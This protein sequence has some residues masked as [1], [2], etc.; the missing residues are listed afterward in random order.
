MDLEL[1]FKKRRGGPKE[2]YKN[3]TVDAELWEAGIYVD[4][5]LGYPW[6]CEQ[7]VGVFPH[8]GALALV[9]PVDTIDWLWGT[10]KIRPAPRR[11]LSE[12]IPTID[13]MQWGQKKKAR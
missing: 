2:V 3:H 13:Y 5:I 6:L 1:T 8:I 11:K 12:T 7:R 9:K 4:V 10:D